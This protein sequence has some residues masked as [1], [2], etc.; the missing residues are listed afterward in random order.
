MHPPS[1]TPDSQDVELDADAVLE[2]AQTGTR[3]MTI[4]G[5]AMRAISIGANL[6]LLVLVTPTELGLLAVARGTFTL[7]QYAA[8]LG[9]GK[10]LL[11]RQQTPSRSEYAALMGLQLAVGSAIVGGGAIWPDLV[12]GFGSIPRQWHWP[13]LATV[14]TI[15]SLAFGT[16]ARVRLERALAYERLAVVDVINVLTLNVGLVLAALIGRFS[17]GVFV[18]LGVAT[19]TANALLY[20]WA[21]GPP[22]SLNF[23]PLR[24]IARQS[25]GF[26]AAASCTV[27]REQ[28][29]PVLIGALFGL[30]VAGLLSF[31]ERV[32]GTLNITFE[33]FRNASIPAA[34]R[35]GADL[36][37][38]KALATRTLIGSMTLTVPFAAIAIAGLPLIGLFFP[39]WAGAVTLTQ[40]YVV[41][42][43][44]YG[45]LAASMEPAAVA[46]LGARAAV[47][48]QASALVLGWTAFAL[49]ALVTLQGTTYLS[50]AVVVT[51]LAP[52]VTLRAIVPES[53]RPAM[54]AELWRI[55]A[56]AVV[57]VALYGVLRAGDISPFVAAALCPALMLAMVPQFRRTLRRFAGGAGENAPIAPS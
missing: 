18:V 5:A 21:P 55:V 57:S 27:L 45:V 47:L 51:Y 40:W 39:K 15:L 7:L 19:V 53:I 24:N 43:G 29:T 38:L 41:A 34:A 36:P 14:V 48:E 23:G 56:A 20:Y 32:A 22:P 3:L 35:L 54:T 8:E 33:G 31:A 49:V 46:L 1:T 9:I 52:V 26:L 42:Y 12:L 13:M 10:A 25:A 16:G 6:L 37:R 28:G 30:P 11:R 44:T 17:V 50:M 2:R 4:R